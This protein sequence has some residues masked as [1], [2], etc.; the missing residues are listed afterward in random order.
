[1]NPPQ[2]F[3][4]IYTCSFA[5]HASLGKLPE[6]EGRRLFQQLINGVSYCHDKGVYHRDLKLENVLID[7]KGSL[8]V[9]DFG[10]SALPQHFVYL[11]YSKFVTNSMTRTPRDYYGTWIRETRIKS[12]PVHASADWYLKNLI[13][14]FCW[15]NGAAAYVY[16]LQL[17]AQWRLLR[18]SAT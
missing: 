2:V 10:L 1:M 18:A 12:A 7:D 16:T 11:H 13:M 15:R 6:K 5:I 8:K 4:M 14:L 9:S 17:E 3:N